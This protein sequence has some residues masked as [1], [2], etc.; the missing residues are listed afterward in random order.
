MDSRIHNDIE[1]SIIEQL[2]GWGMDVEA[3]RGSEGA[4][5]SSPKVP[6]AFSTNVSND[7]SNLTEEEWCSYAGMPSPKAYM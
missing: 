6:R 5:L 7:P 4:S 3:L 2:E 1:E